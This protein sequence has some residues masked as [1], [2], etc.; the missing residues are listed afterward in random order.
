MMDLCPGCFEHKSQL[1]FVLFMFCFGQARQ[2][3]ARTGGCWASFRPRVLPG[4]ASTMFEPG[5]RGLPTKRLPP[6]GEEKQKSLVWGPISCCRDKR[7]NGVS[8]VQYSTRP[9]SLFAVPQ[10]QQTDSQ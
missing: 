8:T 4:R 6:D 3:H 2:C 5:S 9:F 1:C 7:P 10:E